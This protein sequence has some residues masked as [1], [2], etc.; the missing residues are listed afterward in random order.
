[1]DHPPDDSP[2]PSNGTAP[3]ELQPMRQETVNIAADDSPS[4]LDS[5]F[6]VPRPN[7]RL[8]LTIALGLLGVALFP[9]RQEFVPNVFAGVR[10]PGGF[11]WVTAAFAAVLLLHRA[12]KVKAPWRMYALMALVLALSP[13][14]FQDFTSK[15]FEGRVWHA[16][17][18]VIGLLLLA[19][20][21]S[22]AGA[23]RRG[24][25]NLSWPECLLRGPAVALA[26]PLLLF[27][28]RPVGGE[29]PSSRKQVLSRA[30]LAV[31]PCALAA[32]FTLT[33]FGSMLPRKIDWLSTSFFSFSVW[34]WLGCAL[35]FLLSPWPEELYIPKRGRL[36]KAQWAGSLFAAV[37]AGI[38]V[39]LVV[40]A[41]EWDF[42]KGLQYLFSHPLPV[43]P[44]LGWA[45]LMLA[46]LLR[47]FSGFSRI[48]G[49]SKGYNVAFFF[50]IAF[51][52]I[53][54]VIWANW[55]KPL[56]HDMPLLMFL[57]VR[58]ALLFALFF[59]LIPWLAWP[60]L[61][62]MGEFPE[63]HKIGPLGTA[64]FFAVALVP[65]SVAAITDKNLPV[66]YVIS[67]RLFASEFSRDLVGGALDQTT[68]TKWLFLFTWLFST[69]CLTYVAVARWVS[70]RRSRLGYWTF[71]IPAAVLCLYPLI[72]L[73]LPFWWLI[74]YIGAM[75][76]TPRRLYGLLYASAGYITVL[77]F[78]CWAIWPPKRRPGEGSGAFP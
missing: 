29:S 7:V 6:D 36:G 2:I 71:A 60:G 47:V 31:F 65:L 25:S 43:W 64:A 32:G 62:K 66:L 72:I 16:A 21:A 70:D 34:T 53:G 54:L 61:P 76:L 35:L 20:G 9:G 41:G 44:A 67:G 38:G 49:L 14:F 28:S 13:V 5:A 69:I 19:A 74:Q 23:R 68:I 22:V 59:M 10:G 1:M 75:G 48:D 46:G 24:E 17:A 55:D 4:A 12:E 15:T 63:T 50:A 37:L 26:A 8:W 33:H 52:G 56:G 77:S 40:L 39:A 27:A 73:T 18:C 30:A 51:I 78:L 11:A 58:P 42:L 45:L 57:F 3:R